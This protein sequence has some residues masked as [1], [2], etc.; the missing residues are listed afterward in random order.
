MSITDVYRLFRRNEFSALGG[1]AYEVLARRLNMHPTMH[2]NGSVVK[3]G[4]AVATPG[5]STPV[6][7]AP[8]GQINVPQTL[9]I[10]VAHAHVV[11]DG[12]GGTMDLELWRR[13]SSVMTRIG[14][15]SIPSGGG[16][17][18]TVN[19]AI[20][21]PVLQ[22]WDYLFLQPTSLMT[23]GSQG[24]MVDVHFKDDIS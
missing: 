1:L 6:A 20:T 11:A 2:F 4:M 21:D 12:S 5:V 9:E 19:F 8:F 14:T 22:R 23:G 3:A 13:R 10:S 18:Q 16:D 15:V 24:T 17:L 7:M